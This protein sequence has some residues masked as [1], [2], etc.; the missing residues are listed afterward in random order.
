VCLV[1]WGSKNG[2]KKSNSIGGNGPSDAIR[3]TIAVIGREQIIQNQ[4]NAAGARGN[5]NPFVEE[6]PSLADASNDPP[7]RDPEKWIV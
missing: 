2:Y 3:S 6:R 4:Y 5:D 1:P 7:E